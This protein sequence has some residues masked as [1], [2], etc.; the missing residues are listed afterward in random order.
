MPDYRVYFVGPNGRFMDVEDV[1]R[2]SDEDVLAYGESL[3]GRR[4]H[5]EIWQQGRFVGTLRADSEKPEAAKRTTAGQ[6]LRE[7][8]RGALGQVSLLYPA[9]AIS[10]M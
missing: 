5:I 4:D 6:N 8:W 2:P 10:R 9:P 1:E 7:L 3:L